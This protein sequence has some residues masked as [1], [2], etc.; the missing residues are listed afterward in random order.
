MESE[1]SG[2]DKSF[3]DSVHYDGIDFAGKAAG[4][5]DIAV[6]ATVAGMAIL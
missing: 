4:N 5:A 3:V 2:L 1:P 6:T